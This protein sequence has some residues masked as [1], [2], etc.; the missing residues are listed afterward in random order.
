MKYLNVEEFYQKYEELKKNLKSEFF[1][2]E[3]LPE[4][5]EYGVVDWNSVTGNKMLEIIHQAQSS[6]MSQISAFKTDTQNGISNR[7]VRYLQFPLSKYIIRQFSTYLISEEIGE[8]IFIFEQIEDSQLNNSDL[9]D[10]LLFDDN[11]LLKHLYVDGEL[12][13]AHYSND[14]TEISSYLE[15]KKILTLSSIPFKEFLN[16]YNLS[17]KKLI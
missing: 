1:K 11:Q 8:Q 4:Y 9:N 14:K 6:R 13:G 3:V 16:N 12:K 17:V 15:L 5:V 7:R 10:F 2:F